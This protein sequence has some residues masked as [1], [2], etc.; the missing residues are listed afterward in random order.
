MIDRVNTMNNRRNNK[1]HRQLY[2]HS[3]DMCKG[4]HTCTSRV[5]DGTRQ[6]RLYLIQISHTCPIGIRMVEIMSPDCHGKARYLY[7]LEH[8]ANHTCLTNDF[9]NET[10]SL[11]SETY[12]SG[13]LLRAW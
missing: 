10:L 1:L 7:N 2:M 5:S 6:G 8:N 13:S 4:K 3:S 9:A 11:T 12:D